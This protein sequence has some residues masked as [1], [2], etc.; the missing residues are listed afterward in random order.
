MYVGLCGIQL[1]VRGP[2]FISGQDDRKLMQATRECL[3]VAIDACEDG[4]HFAK[5]GL[6]IEYV[7]SQNGEA[8]H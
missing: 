2:D 5:L 1:E 3:R 8:R 7:A 6:L 4:K